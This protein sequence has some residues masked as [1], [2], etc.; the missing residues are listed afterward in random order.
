MIVD[1]KK[2]C[3]ASNLTGRSDHQSQRGRSWRA[4]TA[5]ACTFF[6]EGCL[7]PMP[8]LSVVSVCLGAHTCDTSTPRRAQN[9]NSPGLLPR[10]RTPPSFCAAL[11][12][13][14]TKEAANCHL[15]GAFISVCPDLSFGNIPFDSDFY[16]NSLQV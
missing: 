13:K 1:F 12:A 4:V 16:T 2:G 15:S 5:R 14:R 7:S 3:A 9:R 11:R 10:T 8:A 6:A